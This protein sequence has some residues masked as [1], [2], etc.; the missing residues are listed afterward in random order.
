MAEALRPH[1]PP[2]LKHRLEH[3]VVARFLR[4][5][6]ARPLDE[7]VARGARLGR[8]WHALDASHRGLARRNIAVGLGLGATEAARV[9]RA[10]FENVGRTL[11]EFSLAASRTA[12]LLGR[13]EF[14][15]VE[16]LRAALAGGRGA[17][18]LSGHCGN[19]ELLGARLAREVPLTSVAR[20]MANPLVGELVERQRQA[21]GVRTIDARGAVRGILRAL[22]RGEVV[23]MLLDQSALRSERVFVPFLG[24][25]AAT[26]FSLAMLALKTGAPVL[27][28]FA[29]RDAT[30]RHRVWISPPIPVADSGDRAQRIGVSTA[31]YTAAIEKYVR[32]YP[33]QW[34]WVHNRWKRTREPGEPVWRP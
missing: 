8:L 19:W 22:Q 30:G 31:R 5:L 16:H 33:E 26:N 10:S 27:P 2:R 34:F 21:A 24:R 9:A 12:E 15:G 13:V 28:A 29:A 7:A 32:R 25:P 14:E 17:F 3:A 6:A 1:A 18:I 4:G 23:G 11:A 20:A